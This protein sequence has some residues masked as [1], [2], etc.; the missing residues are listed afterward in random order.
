MVAN[1]NIY[2]EEKNT[3]GSINENIVNNND[4]KKSVSVVLKRC[5]IA[6]RKLRMIADLI[7]KKNVE[8]AMSILKCNQKKCCMYI[9]KLL[10]SAVAIFNKDVLDKI[11]CENLVI[12][13]IKVD[14][15]SMLKRLLPAPQGRGYRIRKRSSHI[16]LI[17]THI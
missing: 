4:K 16:T 17:L 14:S 6:P 8:Q 10:I 13:T 7:R 1:N 9:K 5:P 12:G 2:K 11:D 3:I 15:G